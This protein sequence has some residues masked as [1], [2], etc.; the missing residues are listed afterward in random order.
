MT[1]NWE[2]GAPQRLLQLGVMVS[3]VGLLGAGRGSQIS[4]ITKLKGV[5]L[6][7]IEELQNRLLDVAE[8]VKLP[9]GENVFFLVTNSLVTPEQ[10]HG[11]CPE[12]PVHS[13][14]RPCEDLG[15]WSIKTG[16]CVEFNGTHRTCEIRGWHPMETSSTSPGQRGGSW[17]PQILF[18]PCLARPPGLTPSQVQ[19][20]GHLGHHYFKHYH[21]DPGFNPYLLYSSLRTLWPGLEGSLRNW[22]SWWAPEGGVLEG[23]EERVPAR[24]LVEQ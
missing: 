23:L 12:P 3:V 11:G 5:S 17:L 7:Q 8:F 21:C 20:L 13:L 6:S 22:C 16:Q 19:C 18:V 15:A 1:R 10:V 4:V 24:V 14:P 9:Q 2:V